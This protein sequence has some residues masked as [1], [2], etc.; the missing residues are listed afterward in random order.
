MPTDPNAVGVAYTII[1]CLSVI[2]VFAL[3]LG[4]IAVMR[5]FSYRETLALA[6]KGLVRP[7]GSGRNALR[8]GILLLAIGLALG[9]GLYPLGFNP[10]NAA[11]NVP[12][13]LG[14]WMV[15]ALVPA[16]VGIALIVIYRVTRETPREDGDRAGSEARD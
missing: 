4:F 12:L 11:E 14:P 3:A 2:L 8:W 10:G 7:P 5:Y 9:L 16:F 15:F 1:N 6:E 13:R